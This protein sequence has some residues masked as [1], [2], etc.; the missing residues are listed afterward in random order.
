VI[1]GF[2]VTLQ[3]HASTGNVSASCDFSVGDLKAE[4]SVNNSSGVTLKAPAPRQSGA[5][6][7]EILPLYGYDN[8][9]VG[10]LPVVALIGLFLYGTPLEKL[11]LVELLPICLIRATLAQSKAEFVSA[12]NGSLSITNADI[13]CQVKRVC[14]LD[15][16]TRYFTR[17]RF[18]NW[19]SS[20]YS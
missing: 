11:H 9:L 5:T 16:K 18:G 14:C 20:F 15:S 7:A 12:S 1:K 6:L 13:A 10:S 2:K 19:Q 17:F 8:T 3:W 4:L